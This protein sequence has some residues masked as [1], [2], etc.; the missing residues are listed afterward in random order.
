VRVPRPRCAHT[1]PREVWPGDANAD[2]IANH[3]D[4]LHVGRAYGARGPARTGATTGWDGAA[5]ADWPQF[6][7]GGVNYKHADTNGDG[8][9]DAGDKAAIVANYGRTHGQAPPFEP[10]AATL[11]DPPLYVDLPDSAASG[12]LEV[13]IILGSAAAPVKDLYGLAFTLRFDPAVVDPDRVEIV[14]PTTWFGEPGV[15]VLTLD[16]A[17]AADGSIEVALSRTDQNAVSGY[18]PIAYLRLVIIDD[19]AGIAPRSELAPEQVLAVDAAEHL[20]PISAEP[21]P[22]LVEQQATGVGRIDLLRNLRLIPN[23][24]PGDVRVANKYG[25]P[26]EWIDVIDPQ[27][28]RIGPRRMGTNVISLT[29]LPDGVYVLRMKIGEHVVS[30]R[31]VKLNR[32]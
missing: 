25:L 6:F 2:R 7:A 13:P 31:V 28:R 3:F 10:P 17:F 9:V 4:L 32:D 19:I 8:R 5:A 1:D 30:R 12:A 26:V 21:R 16:R 29:Y 15:N 22:L 20:V 23:P 27:G 11:I 14:F 18:G 24:T